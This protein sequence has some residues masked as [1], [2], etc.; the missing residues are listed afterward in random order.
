MS[1]MT[2]FLF[3]LVLLFT[4]A[5]APAFALPT[6]PPGF[7][8]LDL[9]DPVLKGPGAVGG[10]AVDSVGNVYIVNAGRDGP[11]GDRI[12]KRAPGG[13]ITLFSRPLG[14][15]FSA[16]DELEMDASGNLYIWDRASGRILKIDPQGA[17][18]AFFFTGGAGSSIPRAAG[19]A[20]DANGILF[21]SDQK[22][23]TLRRVAP[24]GTDLGLFA[25][26]VGDVFQMDFGSDGFLYAASVTLGAVLKISPSGSVATLTADPLPVGLAVDRLG[27]GW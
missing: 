2:S 27:G 11:D 20:F 5:A 6:V 4:W 13:A 21:F 15:E 19:L 22:T 26:G 24:D 18:S 8:I 25:L 12:Y 17:A 16:S 10:I 23:D 7:T 3:L 1:R 14:A 9:G